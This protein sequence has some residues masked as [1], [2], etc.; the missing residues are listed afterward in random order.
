MILK[1]SN[2]LPELKGKDPIYTWANVRPR[3]RSRAPVI[4]KHPLSPSEFIMN[5]GFKIGLGMAPQMGK[6]F[7]EFLLLNENKIP[8][9]FLPN[10]SL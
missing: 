7:S 4:G 1:A 5:G 8:T 9:E 6:V 10:E 3:S 2:I